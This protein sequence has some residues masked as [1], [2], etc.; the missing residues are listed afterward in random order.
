MTLRG[1]LRV[2]TISD[3]G[4]DGEGDL[5]IGKTHFDRVRSHGEHKYFTGFIFKFVNY[6]SFGLD[7]LNDLFIPAIDHQQL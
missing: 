4:L 7:V 6:L 1:F 2:L 5:L 3:N